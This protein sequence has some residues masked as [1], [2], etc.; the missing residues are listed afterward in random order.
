MF[1]LLV[2]SAVSMTNAEEK[3]KQALAKLRAPTVGA[4]DLMPSTDAMV[5]ACN[6][7]PQAC[8][9]FEEVCKAAWD[10]DE[11]DDA[12]CVKDRC[13]DYCKAIE[14][15]WCR[16]KLSAGAIAGIV[17]ACVVVVG[18]VV[19]VLVYFFVIR[20]KQQPAQVANKPPGQYCLIRFC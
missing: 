18:V 4:C 14:G 11:D 15:D 13:D 20:P 19:G 7:V 1:V 3:L 2:L 6:Q 12:N 16:S 9:S 8:A 5:S 17:I 10:S